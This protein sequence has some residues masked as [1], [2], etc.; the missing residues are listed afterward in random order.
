MTCTL[1]DIFNCIKHIKPAVSDS[2]EGKLQC[3]LHI[4]IITKRFLDISCHISV[5]P[6]DGVY[7]LYNLV[8]EKGNNLNY[9]QT[10]G[11]QHKHGWN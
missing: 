10:V 9:L 4:I 2:F 11:M 7:K 3:L 1:I 5:F 8:G 6:V